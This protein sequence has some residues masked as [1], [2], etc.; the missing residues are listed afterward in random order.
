MQFP[1]L[2]SPI[3]SEKSRAAAVFGCVNVY[4]ALLNRESFKIA[5]VTSATQW[6]LHNSKG[7]N[8]ASQYHEHNYEVKSQRQQ[9]DLIANSLLTWAKIGHKWGFS[10]KIS[11]CWPE[12]N[13]I[14]VLINS[15]FHLCIRCFFLEMLFYV[16]LKCTFYERQQRILAALLITTNTEQTQFDRLMQK[17]RLQILQNVF[18]RLLDRWRPSLV[19]PFQTQLTALATVLL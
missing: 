11:I 7:S 13:C 15:T 16:P 17:E 5:S 4:F 12:Q 3:C 10:S 19:F 1:V 2:W 9:T 14:L 18:H 6:Q 8:I